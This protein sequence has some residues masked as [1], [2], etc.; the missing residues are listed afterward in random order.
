M[1]EQEPTA[2]GCTADVLHVAFN[3]TPMGFFDSPLQR[4]LAHHE[5]EGWTLLRVVA[6]H[7]YESVAVFV[8][9]DND[10]DREDD[11]PQALPMRIEPG[12]P[13]WPLV[14]G[15]IVLLLALMWSS[16]VA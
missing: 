8:R 16:R 1:I 5:E 12:F 15:P 9:E 11:R 6:H 10:G 3:P 2:M 4:I 7:Q 13:M 14:V